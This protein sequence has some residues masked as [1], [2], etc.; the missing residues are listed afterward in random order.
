MA[1]TRHCHCHPTSSPA[2]APW[3]PCTALRFYWVHSPWKANQGRELDVVPCMPSCQH[4]R[5]E[6]CHIR[7]D[8]QS[9]RHRTKE[10]MNCTGLLDHGSRKYSARG[11]TALNSPTMGQLISSIRAKSGVGLLNQD[12]LHYTTR[13][14]TALDCPT[15][16]RPAGQQAAGRNSA[17][18]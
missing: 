3:D 5:Q 1:C 18:R 12:Q 17:A 2:A 6:A 9:N 13:G 15:K 14:R 16:G 7:S 4:L 11:R 8:M 10:G